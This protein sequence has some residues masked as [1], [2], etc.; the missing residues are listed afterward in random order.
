MKSIS[1]KVFWQTFI[2]SSIFLSIFATYQTLQRVADFDISLWRSKWVF[3]PVL[4]ALNIATGLFGLWRL[5]LKDGTHW[6]EK[7]EFNSTATFG[8]LLGVI[9]ILFGFALTWGMRLFFFTGILPQLMP[10]FWVFLWAS[11]IQTLGLKL[12][13]G[14]KWHTLF[15]FTI[16][17]QGLIYQIYGHLTIV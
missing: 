14:Y 10:I 9:L 7:L 6:A 11:L 5:S 4:F 8:K 3:L 12:I 2:G 15:A 16:L 13:M 1:P 17:V